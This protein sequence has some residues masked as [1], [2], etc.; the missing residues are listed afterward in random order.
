MSR[1]P[2]Q[3]KPRSARRPLGWN[4]AVKWRSP[5]RNAASEI[6]TTVSGANVAPPT[7]QVVRGFTASQPRSSVAHASLGMSMRNLGPLR[8]PNQWVA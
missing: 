4:S 6:P 5:A 7:V 1:P 3:K 8:S 2:H